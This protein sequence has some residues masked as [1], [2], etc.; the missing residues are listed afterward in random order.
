MI[1][2]ELQLNKVF[3]PSLHPPKNLQQA[4]IM[5]MHNRCFAELGIILA[6]SCALPDQYFQ[7]YHL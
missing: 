7:K 5:H 4:V 3:H 1:F 2:T 6:I